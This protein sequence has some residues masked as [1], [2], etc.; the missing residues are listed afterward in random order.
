MRPV[1]VGLQDVVNAEIIS[2][3]EVGEVISLGQSSSP[4]DAPAAGDEEM[5]APPGQIPFGRMFG[6]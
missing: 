6:G 2:G 5:P 3:L 4:A 1:Q